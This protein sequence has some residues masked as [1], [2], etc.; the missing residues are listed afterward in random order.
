MNRNIIRHK[1]NVSKC[2]IHCRG[3]S[4]KNKIIQVLLC[5]VHHTQQLQCLFIYSSL[6]R[7]VTS[8]KAPSG[9][10]CHHKTIPEKTFSLYHTFP[11]TCILTFKS[12][13]THRHDYRC[14][15]CHSLILT[16]V[17]IPPSP[18]K[19]LRNN[20]CCATVMSFLQTAYTDSI[21]NTVKRLERKPSVEKKT[22]MT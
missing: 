18:Q 8:F 19:H 9:Y 17:C 11:F 7:N 3:P 14:G 16:T 10:F 21:V 12:I 22:Q 5:Y 15:K 6:K 2:F 4:S 1:W 20:L 13:C